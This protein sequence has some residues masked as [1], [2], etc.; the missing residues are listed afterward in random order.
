MTLNIDIETYSEADL[1]KCGVYRYAGDKS[2][3]ILLFAYSLD[4]GA[5]QCLD[6]DSGDKIPPEVEDMIF[7]PAIIKSAFNAQFERVCLSSHFNRQIDP[8]GWECTMVKAM[9][10]G[11]PGTLEKVG[12]ALKFGEDKQKL[13]TGKNLIRTFSVPRKDGT[14]LTREDLPEEWDKFI[15]YCTQDVVSE[16]AIREKLGRYKILPEEQSIYEMDQRIND[17][18]VLMETA[19]IEGAVEINGKLTESLFKRAQAITGIDNPNSNAQLKTWIKGLTGDTVESLTK[20]TIP[21]LKNKY[22]DRE[23]IVEALELNQLLSKSSIAK[24]TKMQDMML[25]DKKV[26]GF[27]QFYG[28]SATGRWAGRGVQIQNL[29]QNKLKDLDTARQTVMTGDLQLMD[30]LYDNIPGV[31]S[32]LIRTCFIPDRGSRFIIADFNAIE[33]RILPWFAGESWRNELFRTGGKLYETSASRMFGVPVEKIIP[34]NPEYALRQKGKVAEL[35]LGYQGSVGAMKAM[36]AVKMGIHEEDLPGIVEAWRSQSPNIV[37]FWYA[38]ERNAKKAIRERTTV[39]MQKGLAFIYEPGIL[40]I[41]LPSGRRLAYMRPKL[42]Q[43]DIG[44]KI[45]YE[46]RD[47]KSRASG[48]LETY[49]GKLVENI[50]QATARDCLR[51]CIMAVET[52]GYPVVMHVHDEIICHKTIGEGSLEEV[53]GIM[54]LPLPWAPGLILKGAG[55]ESNYYMKD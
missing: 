10:L 38:V 53:L 36:G 39:K 29:P 1:S 4:G 11:L 20:D 8:K 30:M 28:A 6:L 23:E 51:D 45:T 16:M 41:R 48:R 50:V 15:E 21:E 22:S 7:N 55:F 32:Q 54:G 46:G 47:D 24:Y 37:K 18:G 27:L 3:K 44:E 26:R 34:G 40:F 13:Q 43:F 49:G 31:L 14:R 5:V 9:T 52:K 35:A 25:P 19:L 2:F 33:G 17:R 12:Q 42:E